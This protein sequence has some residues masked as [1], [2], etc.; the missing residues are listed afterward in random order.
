[1]ILPPLLLAATL[2]SG[3]EVTDFR[4]AAFPRTK[5]EYIQQNMDREILEDQIAAAAEKQQIELS[6]TAQAALKTDVLGAE[7][8]QVVRHDINALRVEGAVPQA[9][10]R[11]L[12][13]LGKVENSLGP[14]RLPT[15]ESLLAEELGRGA[16]AIK[17]NEYAYLD[18]EVLPSHGKAT[19]L[20]D[21]KPLKPLPPDK[22][23][24]PVRRV[25]T[26]PGQHTVV[27]EYVDHNP[28]ENEVSVPPWRLGGVTCS[29]LD[30][31]P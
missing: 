10:E 3:Q 15:F 23:K 29:F 21:G 26:T 11:Y 24:Q 19:T 7:F 13:A 1:M 12:L 2:A 28:C 14:R 6:A 20:I 27:V 18:I 5:S 8:E 22:A 17:R 31:T 25:V 16:L 9:L 30:S 4:E